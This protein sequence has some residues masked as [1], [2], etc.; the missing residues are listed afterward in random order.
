MKRLIVG[1]ST[2]LLISIFWACEKDKTAFGDMNLPSELKI[3]SITDSVGGYDYGFVNPAPTD[4]TYIRFYTKA[5][6]SLFK[7]DGS[8]DKMKVDTIYYDGE[9]AKLYTID[10][11]LLPKYKNRLY[12]KFDSNARWYAPPVLFTSTLATW[13]K[14]TTV[15]G[16]GDAIID[17]DIRPRSTNPESTIATRRRLVT[18]Y[19]STRDSSVMYK[20]N[21]SQKSMVEE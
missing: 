14:N 7:A 9:T 2:V 3:V 5:T 19:I 1:L 10:L 12:I 15:A 8:F 17:Y 13:I 4:T 11:V 6:D 18:Q 20:I 21:F 16:V